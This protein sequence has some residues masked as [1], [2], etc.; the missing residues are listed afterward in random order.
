M[1]RA[2]PRTLSGS[3]EMRVFL[4]LVVQPVVA[5]GLAFVSSPLMEWS[6]HAIHGHLDGDLLHFAITQAFA[7][8]VAAFFVSILAALPAAVFVLKRHELTLGR[9]LLWG[10]L[11][12][13]IPSLFGTLLAGVGYGIVGF[14][15]LVLY[16]S[17][18]GM[19]GAAAF[20]AVWVLNRPVQRRQE[21]H[22]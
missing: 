4:G 19:G 12:G 18:L 10:V 8:S 21:N 13:N 16:A 3:E 11:L 20:W 9:A 2:H 7:A 15:R 6:G 14:V 22:A 1:F 17:F 5:A